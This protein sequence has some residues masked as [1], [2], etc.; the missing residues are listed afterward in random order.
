MY[1]KKLNISKEHWT[2]SRVVYEQIKKEIRDGTLTP[3]SPLIISDLAKRYGT[4]RMPVRDAI[5]RLVSEG[6]VLDTPTRRKIV[7]KISENDIKNIYE[8]RIRL[9]S[10]AAGKAVASDRPDLAE[11]EGLLNRMDDSTQEQD[12][13]TVFTLNKQIHFTLYEMAGNPWLLRFISQLWEQTQRNNIALI[14][15][16]RD[17]RHALE[18]LKQHYALHEALAAGDAEQA[19]CLMEKHLAFARDGVL[20][21][22]KE[23]KRQKL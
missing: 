7:P 2:I 20:S 9:E 10:F 11:L 3:G 5:N 6:V 21:H 12:Y 14:P 4:S 18:L 17:S 23:E 15:L 22:V 13:K 1:L 16:I 8:V 19:S